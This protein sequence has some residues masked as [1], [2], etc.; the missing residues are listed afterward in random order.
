VIKGV[1]NPLAGRLIVAALICSW[2]AISNHCAFAAFA[3]K[4][5]APPSACPFHSQPAKPKAPSC[6]TQCCKTLRAVVF[7]M[8]KSWTRDD[9]TF[10]NVDDKF[11]QPTIFAAAQHV[12]PLLLDT[13][14]PCKSSFV[15]LIRSMRAHAPPQLD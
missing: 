4:P 9:A 6:G 1:V 13:G 10:S 15:E 12:L 7:A 11:A 14:P 8:A 3:E 2:I 5:E